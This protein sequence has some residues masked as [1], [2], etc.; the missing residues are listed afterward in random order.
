M[1][2]A[3]RLFRG[4]APPALACARA[5]GSAPPGPPGRGARRAALA[6][7]GALGGLGLALGLW[8]RQAAL[9][10][11]R[12]DEEEK[13]LRQRFMAPPVSGLR[14]LRRRRR[15][16]R[17]RMELLIMETQAEMCRALAAL[18]P[19]ASFSVDSWERKE[20]GGGISCVLQ[21]GEVFEKA[22]VNV[23]VVS[24]LLSEE[25][26]RQMRSRGKSLKAKDGKAASAHLG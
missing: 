16:V 15:E 18:D 4:A 22:G 8:R 7:A 6:A 23:S 25:A 1:A 9:A 14:E 12:E 19:G 26:A 13:E 21:D 3:A 11:A 2:A 10:A 5:L 24:G 20:G 17:S